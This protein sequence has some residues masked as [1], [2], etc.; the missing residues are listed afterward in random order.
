[1]GRQKRNPA[2][3]ATDP[4]VPPMLNSAQ[5][6]E[7]VVAFRLSPRQAKIIEMILHVFDHCMKNQR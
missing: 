5:W 2:M 6:Q 4:K 7:L 3:E 1:M